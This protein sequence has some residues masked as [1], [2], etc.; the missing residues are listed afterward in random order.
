MKKLKVIVVTL[1]LSFTQFVYSEDINIDR[2]IIA[3]T[4]KLEGESYPAF[5]VSLSENKII[6]VIEAVNLETGKLKKNRINADLWIEPGDPEIAALNTNFGDDFEGILT[7][8]TN[9]W[10]SIIHSSYNEIKSPPVGISWNRKLS[11]GDIRKGVVFIVKS[12]NSDIYK[13]RIDRVTESFIQITYKK[14]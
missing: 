4:T 10:L 13:V 1:L 14:L 5:F 11:T 12:T 2:I 6:P 7:E 3:D 9:T 8:G